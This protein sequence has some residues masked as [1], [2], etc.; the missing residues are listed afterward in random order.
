MQP[1]AIAHFV[2]E[3]ADDEFGAGIFAAD[4]AHVP[5]F[6]GRG[7]IYL[8]FS[9]FNILAVACDH[10]KS[11]LSLEAGTEHTRVVPR[12]AI[13]TAAQERSPTGSRKTGQRDVPT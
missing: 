12:P 2:Q 10:R 7:L 6:F 11:N 1:E 8:S 5:T 9:V 4:T 13:Q 3:G